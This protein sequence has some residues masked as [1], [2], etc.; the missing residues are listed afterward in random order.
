MANIGDVSQITLPNGDTASFKDAAMRTE[1]T[2][3]RGEY[4]S[5]DAR[6]DD[7]SGGCWSTMVCW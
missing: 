4:A 1:V 6:L 5:L 2:N 7:M 3:A